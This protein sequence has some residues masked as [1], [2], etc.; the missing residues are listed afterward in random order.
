MKK[1]SLEANLL[2]GRLKEKLS[3]AEMLFD[4][5]SGDQKI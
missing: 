1:P 5:G 3:F 4:A 2:P